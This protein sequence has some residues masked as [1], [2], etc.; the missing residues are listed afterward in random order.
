M[1]VTTAVC[2][3]L[4][5]VARS[6]SRAAVKSAGPPV[7]MNAG[8]STQ[9]GT[10]VF[11]LHRDAYLSKDRVGGHLTYD[12]S[13][14]LQQ[15]GLNVSGT[16]PDRP[17]CEGYAAFMLGFD[18]NAGLWFRM[19]KR[20]ETKHTKP[21]D[22]PS[23]KAKHEVMRVP[24]GTSVLMAPCVGGGGP[25]GSAGGAGGCHGSCTAGGDVHSDD[26]SDDGT[27]GGAGGGM[28][29]GEGGTD[30]EGTGGSPNKRKKKKSRKT[31][32]LSLNDSVL[33]AK[34]TTWQVHWGKK[35]GDNMPVGPGST[36][37]QYV[38][39]TVDIA[40]VHDLLRK[41]CQSHDM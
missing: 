33:R 11:K 20:A 8:F 6:G 36:E 13:A 19:R 18:A 4:F 5:D 41:W 16:V 37:V 32:A 3:A 2:M 22:A 7:I 1:R 38:F 14:I 39:P 27:G 34:V 31:E 40:Q 35:I 23:T 30:N 10:F 24:V 25:F 28:G 17:V 21:Y 29:D 9:R 26:G 12:P 15:E